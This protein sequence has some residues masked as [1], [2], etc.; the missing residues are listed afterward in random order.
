MDFERISD[1]SI[2]IGSFA[3]KISS[4]QIPF[5]KRCQ[6]ELQIYSQALNDIVERTEKAFINK[7]KETAQTIEPLEEVID[8]LN[9]TVH[10]HHLKRL[11]NGKCSIELGIFLSDITAHMERI[12]DHCSNIAIYELQSTNSN[13][14]EHSY[15]DQLDEAESLEFQKNYLHFKQK[16]QLK[17]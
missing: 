2:N 11:R 8:E 4:E 13:I 10:K 16:Y 1:L 17:K 9:K 12:S 7:D 6:E 15:L 3:K 5:T 14:E